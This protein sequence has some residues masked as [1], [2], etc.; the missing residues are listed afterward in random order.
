[1]PANGCPVVL[2]RLIVCKEEREFECL[3]KADELE[4]GGCRQGFSDVPAIE[5]PATS[6]VPGN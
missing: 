2:L 4:L 6:R 5:R 3:G 1:V